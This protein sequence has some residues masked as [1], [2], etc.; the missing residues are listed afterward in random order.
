[1]PR[2]FL[3]RRPLGRTS[4]VATRIGQGDLADRSVPRE[5]CVA[6]LPRALDAGSDVPLRSAREYPTLRLRRAIQHGKG[7][8][9]LHIL[10]ERLGERAFWRG[11][12]EFTARHADGTVTSADLQCAMA[13]APGVDLA[14]LFREWVHPYQRRPEDEGPPSPD[15]RHAPVES[16]AR[17]GRAVVPLARIPPA[18]F[19][20][21]SA[22]P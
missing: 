6:V 7:A 4:F 9:L 1:M 2:R 20:A 15:I 14:S 18:D 21:F 13:G 22:G 8:L 5:R 3:P 19:P 12:A 11:A 16:P 10:R 17:R